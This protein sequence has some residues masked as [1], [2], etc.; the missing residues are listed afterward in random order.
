VSFSDALTAKRMGARVYRGSFQGGARLQ[1]KHPSLPAPRLRSAR[2]G[3]PST[4]GLPLHAASALSKKI[5]NFYLHYS[6]KGR[7]LSTP[8]RSI[9]DR[10]QW[11]RRRSEKASRGGTRRLVLKDNAPASASTRTEDQTSS[12]KSAPCARAS[13]LAPFM[14]KPIETTK[15]SRPSSPGISAA[16]ES[17]A[18]SQ[19]VAVSIHGR[20]TGGFIGPD[21]QKEFRRFRE[22]CH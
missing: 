2:R 7:A 16:T 5:I 10:C 22:S 21:F 11:A 19:A 8:C 17:A 14:E 9:I 13:P 1:N 20:I 6:T 12:R 3:I 4:Q 15:P 18:W